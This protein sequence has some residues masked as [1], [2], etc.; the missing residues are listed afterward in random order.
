MEVMSREV[1][2]LDRRD[3]FTL[4]DTIGYDNKLNAGALSSNT[5]LTQV[6]SHHKSIA[7]LAI[8]VNSK[9]PQLTHGFLE[10]VLCIPK[11]FKT[12]IKENIILVFTNWNQE[13]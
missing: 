12:R 5:S 10:S 8:D 3:N 2:M 1:R 4:I 6:L 13:G 7:T 11:S 9:D